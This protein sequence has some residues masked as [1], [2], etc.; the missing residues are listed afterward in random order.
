[1]RMLCVALVSCV[2]LVWCSGGAA[3]GSLVHLFGLLEH[4]HVMVMSL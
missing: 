3:Q 1:M 2:V 4:V